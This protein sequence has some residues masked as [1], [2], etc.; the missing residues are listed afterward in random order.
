MRDRR[1]SGVL[2][3]VCSTYVV[4]RRMRR[5]HRE[6]SLGLRRESGSVKRIGTW[7]GATTGRGTL[8]GRG[9]S[10]RLG[11]LEGGGVEAGLPT[12]GGDPGRIAD[13]GSGGVDH[14]IEHHLTLDPSIEELGWV[15]DFGWPATGTAGVIGSSAGRLLAA[16]GREHGEQRERGNPGHGCE[17]NGGDASYRE[18][19][20]S[21]GRRNLSGVISASGNGSERRSP[22]CHN[23]PCHTTAETGSARRRGRVGRSHH[24]PSA[25]PN[26]GSRGSRAADQAT[27]QRRR[28][29]SS[30]SSS[31]SPSRTHARRSEA[32]PP[33]RS[34]EDPVEGR[35]VVFASTG[36]PR[37]GVEESLERGPETAD[38]SMSSGIQRAAF[39]ELFGVSGELDKVEAEDSGGGRHVI[40]ITPFGDYRNGMNTGVC[41]AAG[42]FSRALGASA[43]ARVPCPRPPLAAR[44]WVKISDTTSRA[45]PRTRNERIR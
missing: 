28:E 44:T 37:L 20:E 2:P 19:P 45:V 14:E 22:G 15:G 13:H 39:E 36:T 16:P 33:T 8:T 6:E 5:R 26:R 42:G 12:R 17:A 25:E 24:R 29:R 41:R 11:G 4:R 31:T 7:I 23:R 38:F 27:G 1:I 40:S 43:S 35:E 32:T 30:P 18:R 9:E 10:E 21:G 3:M 34:R